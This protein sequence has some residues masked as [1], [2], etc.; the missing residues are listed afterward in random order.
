MKSTREKLL[1]AAEEL[2]L[3]DGYSA[4]RV[5][6]VIQRA[7]VSKGSFYHLFDSKEAMALAT[8]VWAST[9]HPFGE[10][11]REISPRSR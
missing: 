10:Q 7:G 8:L 4:T 6:E 9:S 1:E 5:D 2:I 11:I 3:Q